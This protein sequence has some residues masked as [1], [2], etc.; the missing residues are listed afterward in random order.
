MD[1]DN[2]KIERT[3]AHTE[4][5]LEIMAAQMRVLE[6]MFGTGAPSYSIEV[7]KPEVK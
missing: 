3:L 4:M 7:G 2:D 5:A 6:H 1:E